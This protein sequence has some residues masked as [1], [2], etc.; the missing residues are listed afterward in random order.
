MGINLFLV[1]SRSSTIQ[2]L[3]LFVFTQDILHYP[4]NKYFKYLF[5]KMSYKSIFILVIISDI[6]VKVY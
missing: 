3:F 1:K 4:K 2:D 5:G 6:L